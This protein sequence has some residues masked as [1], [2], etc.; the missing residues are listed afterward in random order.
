MLMEFYLLKTFAQVMNTKS[1]SAAAKALNVT[2]SSVS[3]QIAKLEQQVDGK[4]FQRVGHEIIPTDLA[5]NLNRLATSVLENVREFQEMHQKNLQLPS[6]I[7]R[8]AMPESCQWTPHFQWVM[9][10]LTRYPEV[11]L[12]VDILTNEKIIER[13]L[14]GSI[15]FGFI[16][17]ERPRTEF[18]YEKFSNEMYSAV[19]ADKNLLEPLNGKKEAA[20]RLIKYPGAD[21]YLSAW[22]KAAGLST[23]IKEASH[24]PVL[25]VGTLAGAINAANSGA[26]VAIIPTH[27]VRNELKSNKLIELKIPNPTQASHPIYFVKRHREKQPQRVSV[28]IDLLKRAKTEV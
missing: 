27:C 12:E 11:Q 10:I 15:D 23:R 17:A 5:K 1:F 16:I 19:A 28:I 14:D 7:V 25:R 21:L 18:H 9:G 26:G 13:L 3:Q 8:Y 6:G 22:G 24:Q 4:L 20:L 2:Q